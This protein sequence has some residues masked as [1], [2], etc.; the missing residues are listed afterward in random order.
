M[1]V[2]EATQ[3]DLDYVES[4]QRGSTR[5]DILDTSRVHEKFWE[6]F[7]LEHSRRLWAIEAPDGICVA[8]LGICPMPHSD[9]EVGFLWMAGS[10]HL[11]RWRLGVLRSSGR[12]MD[13]I[14]QA[15]PWRKVIALASSNNPYTLNWATR[16][17]GFKLVKTLQQPMAPYLEYYEL[18]HAP[19][20][21]KA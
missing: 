2:R 15:D 18:E 19:E 17:L 21:P 7:P 3:A 10:E 11:E 20:A 6:V 1:V 5:Q 4:H 12:W 16:W 14:Y 13:V 8:I 9:E